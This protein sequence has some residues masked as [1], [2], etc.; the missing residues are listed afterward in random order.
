MSAALSRRVV[1]ALL[2]LLLAAPALAQDKQ[3]AVVRA[4]SMSNPTRRCWPGARRSASTSAC[5]KTMCRA[6][7][8]GRRRWP[9][10]AC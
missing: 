2:A 3:A 6:A 4:V 8:R 9:A 7:W 5:S 10:R 1:P